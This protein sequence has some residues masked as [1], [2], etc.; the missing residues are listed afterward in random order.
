MTLGSQIC[1]EHGESNF[2][3]S[4]KWSCNNYVELKLLKSNWYPERPWYHFCEI[5]SFKMTTKCSKCNFHKRLDR[6]Q[7][8]LART[9]QTRFPFTNIH[10]SS[11]LIDNI[12]YDH[13][14]DVS[15]HWIWMRNKLLI[16]S[17]PN[18]KKHKC[19]SESAIIWPTM[20]W[21]TTYIYICLTDHH[22]NLKWSENICCDHK[23]GN[24]IVSRI[25]LQC[26]LASREGNRYEY[27][28]PSLR[29]VKNHPCWFYQETL[30]VLSKCCCQIY[31]PPSDK[32]I[33]L[34]RLYIWELLRTA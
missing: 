31:V 25:S 29:S 19:S 13:S 23:F 18:L 14:F 2:I 1:G 12:C 17:I 3:F 6:C 27:F 28:L 11:F 8:H 15:I 24:R 34:I 21:Q 16:F 33:H 4:W 7:W 10:F 5:T 20:K 30:C 26:L 9:I 22:L 32:T